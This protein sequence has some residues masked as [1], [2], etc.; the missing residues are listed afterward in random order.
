MGLQRVYQDSQIPNV[1][2]S[3][4]SATT[5]GT[6]TLIPSVGTNSI[7]IT[8]IIIGNGA[9]QGSVQFGTGVATTLSTTLIGSVYIAAN[10]PGLLHNLGTPIKVST[11]LNFN[12]TAVSCT[13]L[14]ITALYY[15]AP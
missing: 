3:T 15:I 12:V 14:S 8:D 11:N 4:I 10:T 7:Y 1:S 5:A 6:Q 2:S 13:T 9:A